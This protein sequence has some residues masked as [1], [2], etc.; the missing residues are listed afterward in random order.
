[1]PHLQ[2]QLQATLLLWV[3]VMVVRLLLLLEVLVAVAVGKALPIQQLEPLEHQDKA[4]LAEK[5]M[6]MMLLL[7]LKA[8]AAAAVQEL[9]DWTVFLA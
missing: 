1:L 4:M 7:R 8:V 6:E 5:V 3:V 9:L 2:A